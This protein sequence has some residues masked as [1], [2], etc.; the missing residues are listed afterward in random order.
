MDPFFRSTLANVPAAAEKIVFDKLHIV[1]YLV[2]AVN[3]VRRREHR[4]NAAA[5]DSTLSGTK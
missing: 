3:R 1:R 5:G 2:D 4:T